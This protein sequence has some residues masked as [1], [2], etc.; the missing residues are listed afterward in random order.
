MTVLVTA[1][2]PFGGDQLNPAQRILEKLPGVLGAYEIRKLLL[3]VEFIR[4]PEIALKEYDRIS[5]AAV[6]MLG[7]AGGRSCITPENVAKNR[8]T[9]R[10]PDNA[11][12]QPQDLPVVENGPEEFRSTFPAE[13]IVRAVRSL[14]VPCELSCDA[15][16][17]V[18]N[19]LLYRMLAHN[20]G[21]VPAGFI[22]IPFIPEQG[23]EDKPSM[24]EGEILR[25]IIAAIEET[26]RKAAP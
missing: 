12:F 25:G 6:V 16:T 26:I 10:I 14:G 22:H 4:A 7:Q 17:Y 19:A 2:E 5:P 3:P 23:H 15:G 1:F 18:C 11:G 13:R 24:K 8:M 21:R 20:G 9:A